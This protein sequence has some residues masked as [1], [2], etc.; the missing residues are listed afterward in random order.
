MAFVVPLLPSTIEMSAMLSVGSGESSLEIVTTPWPS[1]IVAPTGDE[2]LTRNI[3]F[4]STVVSPLIVIVM[5]F[6]DWPGLNVTV[7]EAAT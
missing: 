4:S 5:V 1:L 2:R 6:A 3:S 7:P